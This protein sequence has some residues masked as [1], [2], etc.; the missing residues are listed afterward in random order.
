MQITRPGQIRAGD[1]IVC[2]YK[3]KKRSYLAMEVLN[4]GT[5]YEEI[6]IDQKNNKYFITSM[7][8]NGTSWAKNVELLPKN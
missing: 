4:A 3:A 1:T 7:A 5:K 6:I 2:D 8:I